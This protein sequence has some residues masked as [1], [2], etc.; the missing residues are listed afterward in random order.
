MKIGPPTGPIGQQYPE[1]GLGLRPKG[2]G[3]EGLMGVYARVPKN[4]EAYW[5]YQEELQP[6][7]LDFK[8]LKPGL[9]ALLALQPKLDIKD[10]LDTKLLNE[11]EQPPMVAS[12]AQPLG[13]LSALIRPD[14]AI[15]AK[16][17]MAPMP[18][19][20]SPDTKH[21]SLTL[22]AIGLGLIEQQRK[23]KSVQQNALGAC[24]FLQALLPSYKGHHLFIED[25]RVELAIN[26]PKLSKKEQDQLKK[27]LQKGLAIKGLYLQQLMINGKEQDHV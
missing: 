10:S 9:N 26:S 7:A 3:F 14:G 17:P 25:N 18:L 6:S 2:Q 16:A 4:D 19:T 5:Q 1:N 13:P 20:A 15:S 27:S 12:K 22:P 23:H 8:G 11:A 24:V 21:L